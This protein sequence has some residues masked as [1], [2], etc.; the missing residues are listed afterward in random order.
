MGHPLTVL[1]FGGS[2]LRDESDLDLGVNEIERWIGAARNGTSGRVIAVV[3][4]FEGT[5]DRLLADARRLSGGGSGS[6][7]RSLDQADP[8]ALAMLLA[9]GE[10]T[11]ASMLGLALARR[12]VAA[13]VLGPAAVSL[14]TEGGGSDAKPTAI[15]AAALHKALDAAPVA[16]VPGFIALDPH[17]HL[18][19]LGRGGSDLTALFLAAELNAERCRLIKDVD[20]VYD[21]DPNAHAN[22]GQARR[23]RSL[24]WDEA[25]TLDGGIVQHKA[26]RLAKSRGLAFEVGSWGREDFTTVCGEASVLFEQSIRPAPVEAGV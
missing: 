8:A 20:G 14:R 22:A 6:G 13:K 17:G 19:L 16:V 11:T 2:V 21:R 23:Y 9:T 15:D 24:H 26:V 25:L 4:A 12:G 1:K 10:F 3:S 18:S 7:G 5:T